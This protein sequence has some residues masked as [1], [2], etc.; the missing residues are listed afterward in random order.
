MKSSETRRKPSAK[1][2]STKKTN[3]GGNGSDRFERIAI[4]AYFRAQA[5]GFA[6]GQ[7]MEDWLTAE[8]ELDRAAA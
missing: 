2:E 5:R 4:A 6:P 1:S 7:D 3:G 8:A